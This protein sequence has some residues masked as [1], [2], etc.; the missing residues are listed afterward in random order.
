M[1]AMPLLSRGACRMAR[2]DW[3]S[4]A[5]YAVVYAP[6]HGIASLGRSPD[7]ARAPV[8][9]ALAGLE[10]HRS[11]EVGRGPV[12]ACVGRTDVGGC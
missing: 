1:M 2:P 12:V 8:R 11:L 5:D 9:P 4:S 6:R 7:Q 10:Q 3:R